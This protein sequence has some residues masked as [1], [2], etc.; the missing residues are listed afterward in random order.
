M[1]QESTPIRE[2]PKYN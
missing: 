2:D 1:I